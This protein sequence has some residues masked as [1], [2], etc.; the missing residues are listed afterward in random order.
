MQVQSPASRLGDK[1][2]VFEPPDLSDLNVD[3]RDTDAERR[4]REAGGNPASPGSVDVAIEPGNTM[5]MASFWGNRE[6]MA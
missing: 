1:G 3:V 4:A 6:A 2:H 5:K